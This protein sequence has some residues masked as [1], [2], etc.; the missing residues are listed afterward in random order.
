MLR[1]DQIFRVLSVPAGTSA[2]KVEEAEVSVRPRFMGSTRASFIS[3]S[4]RK[5]MGTRHTRHNR[6]LKIYWPV[7]VERTTKH[8]RVRLNV[9]LN[10]IFQK[11]DIDSSV[12]YGLPP[13]VQ[14]EQFYTDFGW[15]RA[16][17]CC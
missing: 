2:A 14:G 12:S 11:E 5:H 8:Q 16:H 17:L 4:M 9:A 3:L 7:R 15:Q 13:S 10:Y 6:G 1:T